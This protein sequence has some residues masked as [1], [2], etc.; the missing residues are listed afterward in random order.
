MIDE[1]FLGRLVDASPVDL[2]ASGI[3]GAR[4]FWPWRMN[5]AGAEA[6]HRHAAKCDQYV[7]DSNFKDA[8]VTNCDALDKAADLNADAAVLADVFQDKEATVDALLDGLETADDHRF[9][10]TVVLPL[11]APHVECFRDLAPSVGRGADR[12]HGRPPDRRQRDLRRRRRERAELPRG[13][14]RRRV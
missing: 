3:D 14:A 2:Y 1:E 9:G 7:V 10:G 8:T 5:K 13:P 12:V 6:D 11:Q 4:A